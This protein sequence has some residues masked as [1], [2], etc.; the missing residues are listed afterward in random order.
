[1][2]GYLTTAS[3]RPVAFAVMANNQPSGLPPLRRAIDAIVNV[4]AER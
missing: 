4:L 1:L 2:S 3:G